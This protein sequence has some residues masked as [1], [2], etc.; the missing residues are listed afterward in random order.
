LAKLQCSI[1]IRLKVW[2]GEGFS[3]RAMVQGF[4]MD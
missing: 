1:E 3:M 2:N 4:G